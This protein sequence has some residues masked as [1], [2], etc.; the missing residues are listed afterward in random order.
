MG[1]ILS[2]MNSIC[3]LTPYFITI[4]LNCPSINH[5]TPKWVLSIR[6]INKKYVCISHFSSVC[7]MPCL[8]HS[9]WFDTL[10]IYDAEY[11]LKSFSLCNFFQS[12]LI[13]SQ[14][15]TFSSAL[16]LK[17]PSF[18]VTHLGGEIK[19]RT[20]CKTKREIWLCVPLLAVYVQL[21]LI[22]TLLH[23]FIVYHYMFWLNWP[24]S[25][26]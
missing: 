4:H 10:I 7:Y 6:F 23:L 20:Q 15:K 8:F 3:S 14:H 21:W 1:P 11:K 19:F 12:S 16:G 18:Y 9:P 13:S 25:G 24:S 5:R 26:L 22:F 2:T 17:H